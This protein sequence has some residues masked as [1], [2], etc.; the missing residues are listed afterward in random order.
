MYG[1]IHKVNGLKSPSITN[2]KHLLHIA[3][4]SQTLEAENFRSRR[5]L[6]LRVCQLGN[7]PLPMNIAC[8]I[9]IS[10]PNYLVKKAGFTVAFCE[11]G[12]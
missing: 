1:F 8:A 7:A 4:E 9:F 10:S 6:V 3:P 12:V 11:F 5:S 2:E